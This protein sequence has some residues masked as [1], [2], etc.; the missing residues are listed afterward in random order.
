[1]NRPQRGLLTQSTRGTPAPC[2]HAHG[3]CR[4]VDELP[5][6]L[7]HTRT[8]VAV[9][10]VTAATVTVTAVTTT[11]QA[12]Y[13]GHPHH[14]PI[15]PPRI[16]ITCRRVNGHTIATPTFQHTDTGP[17]VHVVTHTH[18]L[19]HLA[20]QVRFTLLALPP[21]APPEH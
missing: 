4:H 9:T 3:R 1:M 10:T 18:T 5:R 7:D 20:E 15:Q 13:Q 21:L 8:T 12:H 11:Y 6:L 16:N 14:S 19:T 2:S 17:S